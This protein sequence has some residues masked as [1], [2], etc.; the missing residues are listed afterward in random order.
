[1]ATQVI[2][3]EH[4]DLS[5]LIIRKKAITAKND[6]TL[7]TEIGCGE[8]VAFVIKQV[9]FIGGLR[10]RAMFGGYG[11]TQRTVSETVQHRRF[12]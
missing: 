11:I 9:S 4:L 6:A 3:K 5:Q 2:S 8:F 7:C 10:V 12:E 1:M